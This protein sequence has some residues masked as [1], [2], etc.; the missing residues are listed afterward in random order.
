MCLY[1]SSQVAL[2]GEGL[3]T[4]HKVA[5][6]RLLA[7]V[8]SD[9]ALKQPRSREGLSAVRTLAVLVVGADVHGKSRHG[10]VDL[11][12]NRAATRLLVLQ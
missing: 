10:D 7:G 2:I 8:R 12:T 6:E 9:V 3:Q 11:I 5:L 4:P 1:V